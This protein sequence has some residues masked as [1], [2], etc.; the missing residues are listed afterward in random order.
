MMHEWKKGELGIV[1]NFPKGS[2]FTPGTV[3]RFELDS[4]FYVGYWSIVFGPT[5]TDLQWF[6]RDLGL[7]MDYSGFMTPLPDGYE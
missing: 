4:G 6:N 2:T 3:V 1:G 5:P 7:W